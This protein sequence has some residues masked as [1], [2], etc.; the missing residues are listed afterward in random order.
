MHDQH[1]V[2]PR[3]HPVA[4][5]HGCIA[6]DALFKGTELFIALAVKRNLNNCR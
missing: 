1:K 5:L 2:W 3:R 4:L 6:V